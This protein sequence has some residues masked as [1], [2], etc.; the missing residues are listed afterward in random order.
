MEKEVVAMIEKDTANAMFGIII[1]SSIGIAIYAILITSI[2][3]F[4]L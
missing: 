4:L 2:Y 1:G 3:Y